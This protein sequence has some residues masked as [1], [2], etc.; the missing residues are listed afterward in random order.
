MIFCGKTQV[1]RSFLKWKVNSLLISQLV[2]LGGWAPI[3]HS[4]H[5]A[6]SAPSSI[7]SPSVA[8]ASCDWCRETMRNPFEWLITELS[9]LS[10][11]GKTWPD[12]LVNA[13]R[14]MDNLGVVKSLPKVE[15]RMSRMRSWPVSF[16]RVPSLEQSPRPLAV[17]N[18]CK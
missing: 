18:S 1:Q 3:Q 6:S 14:H 8:A 16:M 10:K 17:L 7:W 12:S 9:I 11:S 5:V 13:L 15:D 2:L 4:N